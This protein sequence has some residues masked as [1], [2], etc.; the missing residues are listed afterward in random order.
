MQYCYE[1]ILS[2]PL[3]RHELEAC[4]PGSILW[5]QELTDEK[6]L[7]KAGDILMVRKGVV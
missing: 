4:F 5:F 3:G 2:K 7:S 6:I 1:V